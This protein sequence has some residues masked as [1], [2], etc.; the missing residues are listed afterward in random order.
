VTEETSPLPAAQAAFVDA[1]PAA[2]TGSETILIEH[3][4]GRTLAADLTA[5][6][7]SPPYHRAIVEGYVVHAAATEGADAEEPVSFKV[8]G[9]VNPGDD[10]F[11]HL[12]G[13]GAIQVATGSILPDGPIAVVRMWE[14]EVDAGT[15]T[16]KRPFP[17]R[18][19]VEDMGCDVARGDT[20]LAAGTALGP[21]DIGTIASLGIDRVQVA[22]RPLVTLFASGDEVVPYTDAMRPGAIRD[23]N[24]P[25]LAAAVAAAGGETE[26]GGI[27]ADDFDDFV[28]KVRAALAASDMV[29]IS[30]GTAVGG[31]D[32][33]SDL[34]REVGR[35][36]VDGVPMRSGRPLIMG[37]AEGKPIVCVAGHPPEALR[38]F[39]LFG[40]AAI[41]RITGRNAPLPEDE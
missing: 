2:T 5:P 35:L 34:V 1:L 20:V 11:P 26:T 12:P 9:Q 41:D 15:I 21:L 14:A 38:G 16:I 30:G 7:D 29:L 18:F 3:A 4:L 8:V 36:V 23:S 40:K 27:V 39:H 33:I 17:P 37:H 25:M 19:F 32:F 13:D 31:R 24:T 10:S 6:E 28:A 22:R